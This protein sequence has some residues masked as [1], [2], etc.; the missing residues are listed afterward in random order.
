MWVCGSRSF[1]QL[2]F[3]Q[4]LSKRTRFFPTYNRCCVFVTQERFELSLELRMSIL[5]PSLLSLPL[6]LSSLVH[7]YIHLRRA[8]LSLH[9]DDDFWER[10]VLTSHTNSTTQLHVLEGDTLPCRA[11]Y[12]SHGDVRT[13]TVACSRKMRYPCMLVSPAYAY[14][15]HQHQT[16]KEIARQ[17]SN[18]R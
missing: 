6:S 8:R 9:C 3:T 12:S 15:Q 11:T 2:R 5:T 14:K 17:C 10:L 18:V 7:D 16:T 4:Y 1:G 13:L